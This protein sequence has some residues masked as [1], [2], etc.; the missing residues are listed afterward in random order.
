M[1]FTESIIAARE[2]VGLKPTH[3]AR[4]A[5]LSHSTLLRWEDGTRFPPRFAT[6]A[7]YLEAIGARKRDTA[8]V[9]RAYH[10]AHREPVVPPG[11]AA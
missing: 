11:E 8:A 9:E 7:A 2:A 1:T 4:R 10:A 3:A 5:G 6:V